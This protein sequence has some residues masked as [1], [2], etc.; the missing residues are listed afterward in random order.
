MKPKY[1]DKS[2]CLALL[3]KQ[4]D[5]PIVRQLDEYLDNTNKGV[6]GHEGLI[7]NLIKHNEKTICKKSRFY[8]IINL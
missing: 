7:E 3:P 2:N 6:S 4:Q 8:N 5:A 1:I